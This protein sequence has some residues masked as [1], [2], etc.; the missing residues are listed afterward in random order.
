MNTSRGRAI[1][2]KS[3][4]PILFTWAKLPTEQRSDS[5]RIL[6]TS[7]LE[8]LRDIGALSQ[9]KQGSRRALVSGSSHGRA[10]PSRWSSG[11]DRRPARQCSRGA[12][13]R[14]KRTPATR[15]RAS[16]GG[17]VPAR[18]IVPGTRPIPAIR[19]ATWT[20]GSLFEST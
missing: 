13:V 4:Q 12:I 5:A 10:S 1:G 15:F 2:L 18:A 19:S 6:A 11:A 3:D 14:P 9:S 20:R 8:R 17:V 7:M 16:S